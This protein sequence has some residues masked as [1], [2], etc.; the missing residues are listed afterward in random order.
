VKN[1]YQCKHCGTVSYSA[2]WGPPRICPTCGKK[3]EGTY[4]PWKKNPTR[5]HRRKVAK[6]P[7]AIT[8]WMLLAIG[9]GWLVNR[10]KG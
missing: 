5:K 9:I 10:S 1:P 2:G 8:V 4:I 7:V 3:W 6:F